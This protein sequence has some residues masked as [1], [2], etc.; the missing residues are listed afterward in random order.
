MIADEQQWGKINL[1]QSGVHVYREC[2]L[3]GPRESIQ[4]QE[5]A[6]IYTFI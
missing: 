2:I 6:V 3:I 5:E 4:G 1:G